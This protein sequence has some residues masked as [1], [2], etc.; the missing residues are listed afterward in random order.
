MYGQVADS[1]QRKVVLQGAIN[2]RDLGG[3]TTKEGK[4]VRW[5]TIYRAAELS[6]LTESDLNDLE[7]R[8]IKTVVDFRG[9]SEIATAKDKLPKDAI[10]YNYDAGSRSLNQR[11]WF[12]ELKTPG[13]ADS[14]M[15]SFYGVIDSLKFRYQPFFKN[16]LE[17]KEGDALVFH[18]T[19][20]KD[21]TGIASALFLLA[22]GVDEE[23]VLKDYEASNF[24]RKD[25]NVRQFEK[26]KSMGIDFDSFQKIMGVNKTY[27]KKTLEVIRSK[28]GNINAYLFKELGLDEDKVRLLKN[29][30]LL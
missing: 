11:S 30:F 24:Y 26:M 28:Y 20:G 22:L 4:T 21:R 5:G 2:F 7:K 25:E 13:K 1:L 6:K 3:Y 17:L 15:V 12:A 9:P 18:C 16:L 29:K 27:L 19:A 10:Y 14:L 23:T 8:H